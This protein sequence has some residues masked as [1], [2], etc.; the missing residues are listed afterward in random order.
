MIC[1]IDLC[2]T[3]TTQIN[4]GYCSYHQRERAEAAEADN[5]ALRGT[6]RD[7][8]L[9][10]EEAEAQLTVA[11]ATIVTLTKERDEARRTIE[12]QAAELNHYHRLQADIDMGVIELVMPGEVSEVIDTDEL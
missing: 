3:E 2:R 11:A 7:E 5:A 9:R 6:L 12:A 1:R 10:A 8:I 4:G